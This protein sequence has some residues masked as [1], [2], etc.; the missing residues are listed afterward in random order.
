MKKK[1]ILFVIVILVVVLS[2]I[3]FFTRPEV[4]GNMTKKFN[5]PTTNVSNILFSGEANEKIRN[6]NCNDD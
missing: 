4:L 2:S 1:K 3:W 6:R 5:E